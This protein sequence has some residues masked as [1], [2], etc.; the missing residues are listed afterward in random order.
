MFSGFVSFNVR[1][2]LVFSVGSMDFALDK[3]L[4]EMSIEEEKPV[5]LR[6]APSLSAKERN[7]CSLIGRLL[8]PENQKMSSLI[9]DM[10]RLWRSYHRS[11]GFALSNEK[12]QFIF[13]SESEFQGVLDAGAWTYN[14]WSLVLERWVEKPPEDYLQ[15]LPIWVRIR[16]IPLCCYDAVQIEEMVEYLGQVL[17]VA[18]DPLKPQSKGY[19]RAIIFHDVTKPL[20]N[21]KEFE[22][23]Q[24][25]LFTIGFEYKRIR[26]TLLPMSATYA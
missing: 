1:L 24:G 5:K 10:P 6:S 11:R 18:F 7:G 3:A 22:T 15:L 9:H 13:D 16:N 19:V 12:F 17:E 2:S 20:K 8:N 23:Q 21:S 25:E 26:K 4:R 14:D